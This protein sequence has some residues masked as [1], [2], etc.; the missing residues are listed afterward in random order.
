M[1]RYAVADEIVP[2]FKRKSPAREKPP[3]GFA[4]LREQNW[5]PASPRLLFQR[6]KKRGPHARARLIRTAV[7]MVDMPI[8][9][10]IAIANGLARLVHRHEEDAPRCSCLVT[11]R[12][13]HRRAPG[14][15]L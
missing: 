1:D 13:G 15:D 3:G 12:I 5:K 4:G 11:R 9:L 10:Q 2:P 14:R 6:G 7:Q 8:R